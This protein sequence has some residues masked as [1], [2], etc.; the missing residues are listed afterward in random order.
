MA[1]IFLWPGSTQFTIEYIAQN[2][3][4][5]SKYAINLRANKM[6]WLSLSTSLQLEKLENKNSIKLTLTT[7]DQVYFKFLN[8]EKPDEYLTN[9][10]LIFF[11]NTQKE[12]IIKSNWVHKTKARTVELGLLFTNSEQVL[13]KLRLHS[14]YEF[15]LHKLI[16]FLR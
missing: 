7:P 2:D 3:T 10:D 6:Q 5:K 8:I 11:P 15:S 12:R 4:Q 14:M 16:L 9:V 1:L 13:Q